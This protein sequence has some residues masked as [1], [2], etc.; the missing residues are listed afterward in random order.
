MKLINRFGEIFYEKNEALIT[1]PFERLNTDSVELLEENYRTKVKEMNYPDTFIYA[2]SFSVLRDRLQM[3]YDL[4]ECVAF[5]NI[6]KVKL[7]DMLPYLYSMIDIAKL[8]ANILWDKNNFVIDTT[9]KKVKAFIYEF[10]GFPLYKKDNSVDG[11]KELILLAL[12]NSQSI[13]AKPKRADFLEKTD[14]VFQFSEDVIASNSID[15]IENVISSYEREKEHEARLNEQKRLEKEQNSIWQKAK[16]K[17]IPPKKEQSTEEQ[18]KS[19]LT[20]SVKQKDKDTSKDW[21]DKVTSPKAMIII[22][23]IVAIF[24]VVFSFV[25]V[26]GE[27]AEKEAKAKEKVEQNEKIKEAY[28]L[29][30]TGDEEKKDEAYAKLDAIGY[31]NLTD[32]EDKET[33]INWYI[34]Q[35]KYAKAIKTNPDS[36]Y[37]VSND[38]LSKHNIINRDDDES[39]SQEEKDKAIDELETLETSFENNELLKFD[40]ASLQNDYSTMAENSNLK[41]IDKRRGKKIAQSYA[42]DNQFEELEE[43]MD[44]YKEDQSSYENIRDYYDRLFDKNTT[45]KESQ[46]KVVE[47]KSDIEEKKNDESS[48]DDKKKSKKIKK[49]IDDLEKELKSEEENIT[50]IDESIKKIE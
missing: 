27:N 24:M 23:S 3:S 39:P 36:V 31:D 35:D 46:D 32:D 25:D 5:H 15:E 1:M 48:T 19:Q 44:G 38:I 45:K 6:H 11:L 28:R 49:E 40:I 14:E 17:V 47:L 21:L 42:I 7:K 4:A 16:N 29:Y 41:K 22:G 8:D 9:E 2:N 26:D 37:E 20:Q 50:D 33:L 18:L 10:E 13:I 43:M 12:T 30:V 34:E